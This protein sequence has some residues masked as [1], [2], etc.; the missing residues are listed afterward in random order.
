MCSLS[1]GSTVK[2]SMQSFFLSQEWQLC[3]TA[4]KMWKQAV[5]LTSPLPRLEQSHSYD[6]NYVH[7]FPTPK[8][9]NISAPAVACIKRKNFPSKITITFV[10][11]VCNKH[12]VH[13]FCKVSCKWT[14]F[15]VSASSLS[16]SSMLWSPFHDISFA[17]CCNN[18]LVRWKW[19]SPIVFNKQTNSSCL[20]STCLK[21]SLSRNIILTLNLSACIVH[22]SL[23]C[24]SKINS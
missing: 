19:P 10:S 12:V 1:Q 24:P 18:Y 11:T 16:H 4:V 20:F 17:A 13:P 14:M 2:H 8:T 15:R 5:P 22:L 23:P 7:V 9:T 21:K 6:N 3:V